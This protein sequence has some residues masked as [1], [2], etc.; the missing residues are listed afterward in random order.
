ME[1]RKGR[2]NKEKP[3]RDIWEIKRW[4]GWRGLAG[5]AREGRGSPWRAKSLGGSGVEPPTA[6]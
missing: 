4:G 3:E 1:E 6:L 5:G 2:H